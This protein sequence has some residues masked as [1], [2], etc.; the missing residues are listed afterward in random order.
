[1]N[2]DIAYKRFNINTHL[3]DIE[4]LDWLDMINQTNAACRMAMEISISRSAEYR[5]DIESLQQKYIFALK[6]LSFFLQQSIKPIGVE[7]HTFQSFKP[8]IENLVKK[9]QLKEE[10]LTVFTT[11]Q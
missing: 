10:I 4:N 9:G 5:R 6:G 8:L 7:E 1:M 2:Y 11:E 3:K